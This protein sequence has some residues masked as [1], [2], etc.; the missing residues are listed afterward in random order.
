MSEGINILQ[1]PRA[2]RLPEGGVTQSVVGV[3]LSLIK[4]KR[5]RME[6]IYFVVKD[7]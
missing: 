2:H 4:K 6:K 5:K 1:G 7:S 3:G